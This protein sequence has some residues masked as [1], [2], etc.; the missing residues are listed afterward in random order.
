MTLTRRHAWILFAIAAWNLVI[1]STFIKNLIEDSGRT[2]GFYVAHTV[3]IAVDLLIA[4][5]LALLGW[6][7]WRA[8]RQ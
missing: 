1:W 8:D 3:L 5:V 4:V 6:K 2:T 7:I